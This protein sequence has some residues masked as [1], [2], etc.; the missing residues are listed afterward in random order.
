MPLTSKG[1]KIM[2][3]MSSEYG[4]EKGKRVFYAS[5]NKGRIKGV[6]AARARMVVDRLAAAYDARKRKA[7]DEL[8]QTYNAR[9]GLPST[10][11]SVI[12]SIGETHDNRAVVRAVGKLSRLARDT[13]R[14][15]PRMGRPTTADHTD[16]KRLP[17][18]Y[19]ETPY[20]V[21]PTANWDAYRKGKPTND[22]K[23]NIRDAIRSSPKL[24]KAFDT[25]RPGE[26]LPKLWQSGITWGTREGGAHTWQPYDQTKD[27]RSVVKAFADKRRATSRDIDGAENTL[28]MGQPGETLSGWGVPMAGPDKT[29]PSLVYFKGSAKDAIKRFISTKDLVHPDV[30]AVAKLGGG[31][32]PR[33]AA[34]RPMA[35]AARPTQGTAGI[36]GGG[37]GLAKIVESHTKEYHMQ[38]PP[39]PPTINTAIPGAGAGTR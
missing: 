27:A 34:A 19:S 3:A 20:G 12:R 33:A 26:P 1:Q 6:D 25:V 18:G 29:P 14:R 23:R 30:A 35:Q 31:V 39:K 22:A 17:P 9:E 15:A 37:H 24:S 4:S 8:P 38:P 7:T 10:S 28:Q 13:L 16:D 36:P 11:R 21:V 32:Q 5:R 2:S